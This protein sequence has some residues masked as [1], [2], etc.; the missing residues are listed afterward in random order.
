[1]AQSRAEILQTSKSAARYK[2]VY[3]ATGDELLAVQ[4]LTHAPAHVVSYA[5]LHTAF[6]RCFGMM[7]AWLLA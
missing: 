7:K 4:I 2:Q 3:R 1:M 5:P 6:S